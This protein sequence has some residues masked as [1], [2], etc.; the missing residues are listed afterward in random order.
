MLWRRRQWKAGQVVSPPG[1]SPGE[2]HRLPGSN[3]NVPLFPLH[4]FCP[5]DPTE[6]GAGVQALETPSPGVLHPFA[7]LKAAHPL[8][9]LLQTCGPLWFEALC[10]SRCPPLS[11]LNEPLW[12]FQPPLCL[13]LLF[14]GEKATYLFRCDHFNTTSFPFLGFSSTAFLNSFILPKNNGFLNISRV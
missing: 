11:G 6:A 7:K 4:Q 1:Q 10:L 8:Q 12:T 3:K 13:R 14:H 5:S 2:G 9:I